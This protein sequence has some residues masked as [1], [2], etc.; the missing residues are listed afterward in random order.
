MYTIKQASLRSGVGVPLIRAWERRYGVLQPRRT[1]SGYRMYDDAAIATLVR[2]RQLTEAGW[3]ASEASRAIMAGEVPTASDVPAAAP[4][5][6]LDHRLDLAHR[7]VEVARLR[8]VAGLGAVL[9]E[10]LSQGSFESVVDRLLMPALVALGAEWAEGRLEIAAE[11]AATAAVQ[12]RLSTLFE[13]AAAV[14]GPRAVVGLP[15]GARHELGALAFGVALRRLGAGVLYLGA[16]VPASSW[17][18]VMRHPR[19]R[20]AVIAVVLEEDRPRALEVIRAIKAAVAGCPVA[21]GGQAARWDEGR[22]AGAI[23]LPEHIGE[24]ARV[25]SE[26]IRVRSERSDR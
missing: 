9:D 22:D 23:V 15:P 3:S 18:E 14:D 24:A 25:A 8:D 19:H 21:V 5:Q 13:A 4:S 16:D 20:L 6:A 1:G 17:A 7:F 2:I 10:M 26:M 12:R 11:H